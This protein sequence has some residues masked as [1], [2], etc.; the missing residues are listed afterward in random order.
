MTSTWVD[1]HTSRWPPRLSRQDG[2]DSNCPYAASVATTLGVPASQNGHFMTAIL[3]KR[4]VNACVDS[5]AFGFGAGICIASLACASLS[6]LQA[7]A[8]TP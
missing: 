4:G 7:L 3:A 6:V 2:P 5:A 8:N 1:P